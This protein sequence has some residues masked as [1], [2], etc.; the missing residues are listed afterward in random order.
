LVVQ[1]VASRYTDCAREEIT[2]TAGPEKKNSIRP[3]HINVVGMAAMLVLFTTG[4]IYMIIMNDMM[5]K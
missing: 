2:L 3:H 5:L 1:P 4:I